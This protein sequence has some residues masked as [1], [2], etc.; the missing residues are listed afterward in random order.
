MGDL[1][2]RAR[3]GV[4]L[5]AL[6]AATL[7]TGCKSQGANMA[8]GNGCAD[9][10]MIDDMEDGDRLVC[11]SNGRHGEWYTKDDGT[12]TNI[13]P[14][15]DFTQTLIPGGRGTSRYAARLT[16]FGFTS[17]G[18]SMGFH[19]NGEGPAAQ[20]FDASATQGIKFWMKS[21]VPVG[22]SFTLPETLAIGEAGGTCVDK[23][24]EF[25]C[26][27]HF[28]FS[29]PSPKPDEWVEYNVPFSTL[30]QS[31]NIVDFNGN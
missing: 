29:I 4:V 23:A 15:G 6:V 18:A 1:E 16:G 17:W 5:W 7:A 2:L 14:K 10:L 31:F 3:H 27:N 13:S 21:T 19:L 30:S 12:S 20:P 8:R 25:N 9:P 26:G 22:V 24:A 11:G 28:S